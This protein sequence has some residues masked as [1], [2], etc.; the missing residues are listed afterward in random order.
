MSGETAVHFRW[1]LEDGLALVEI[2]SR[3]LNQP[4]FAEELRGELLA[5]LA[6]GRADRILLDF[7]DTEYMSSTTFAALVLFSKAATAA[8]VRLAICGMIP[9]VRRGAE[10]MCL[11]Q[12]IPY[13]DDRASGLAALR[14]VETV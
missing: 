14:S 11:D 3:E 6:T 7:S 5:L 4:R 2:L 1:Y 10:I 12:I 13:Y 9:A 8:G